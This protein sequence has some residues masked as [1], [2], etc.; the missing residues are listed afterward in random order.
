MAS[1][2]RKGGKLE[3][4]SSVIGS[5]AE[6]RRVTNMVKWN[7]PDSEKF[8]NKTIFMD[9]SHCDSDKTYN[10][11]RTGKDRRHIQNSVAQANSIN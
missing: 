6:K 10:G 8:V 11:Y 4:L 7:I 2:I 1:E 5:H 3:K 9:S